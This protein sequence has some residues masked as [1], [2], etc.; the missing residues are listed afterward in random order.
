M[1]IKSTSDFS[2]WCNIVEIHHFKRNSKIIWFSSAEKNRSEFVKWSNT[3]EIH[4]VARNSKIESIWSPEKVHPTFMDDEIL[5]KFIIVIKILKLFRFDAQKKY[6]V[7]FSMIE[8]SW[9]SSCWGKFWNYHISM[10]RKSTSHF[11]QRLD[12]VEIH[13]F[14]RNSKMIPFSWRE[15]LH[16]T[17]VNDQI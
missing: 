16:W 11:G 6:I 2:Q 7:C 3:V 1:K 15:K 4:H 5:L 12:N 10:K 17:L 13:N 14:D 8:Y 9:N